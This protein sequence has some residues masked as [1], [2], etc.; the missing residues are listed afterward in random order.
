MREAGGLHRKTPTKARSPE[1][2]CVSVQLSVR[3][4]RRLLYTRVPGINRWR[5]PQNFTKGI[6]QVPGMFLQIGCIVQ[7]G[8]SSLG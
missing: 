5:F 2:V 8:F 4:V 3:Y 6:Y 1:S 7:D